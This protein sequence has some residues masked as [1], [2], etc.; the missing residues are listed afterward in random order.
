MGIFVAA[1]SIAAFIYY[2]VI[3]TLWL[4]RHTVWSTVL[5]SGAGAFPPLIGWLAVTGRIELTPILLFAIIALWSPPHFWSLAI[6]RSQ[7]YKTIG[8]E[9]TPARNT[10]LL[11]VVFS[12]LLVI[13][14]LLLV[15]TA[16][17]G[18][19]YTA[20]AAV[21]GI[22]FLILA[23]RLQSAK[24]PLASRYLYLYSMFY[25]LLLFSAMLVDRI[26]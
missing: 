13:S 4:K 22:A 9:I 6:F 25:L 12:I 19:L 16:K 20:S 14:S 10:P 17:L 15:P 26:L 2:V 21:L 23:V 18:M 7:E 24:N 1:L 3:Y 5:G 11:I 8:L